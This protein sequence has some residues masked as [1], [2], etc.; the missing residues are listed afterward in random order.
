MKFLALLAALALEQTRPLRPGN[1]ARLGFDHYLHVLEGQFNGGERRH[2][3]IAWLLAVLPIIAAVLAIYH[4]L[5]ELNPVAAW[6]W[7]I[8]VTRCII[9]IFLTF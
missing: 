2:G 4:V 6:L 7:N 1:P 8:A 3:L 9:C 5:Y